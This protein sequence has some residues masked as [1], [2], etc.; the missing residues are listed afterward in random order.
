MSAAAGARPVYLARAPA[1][2]GRGYDDDSDCSV[3]FKWL[4]EERRE[5][6][7]ARSPALSLARS[8]K[9]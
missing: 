4:R 2:V 5:L 6:T 3:D 9:R 8:L 1:L 7:R